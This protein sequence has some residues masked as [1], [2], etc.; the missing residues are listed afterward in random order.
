M[1][2]LF[3]NRFVK[4]FGAGFIWKILSGG[5]WIRKLQNTWGISLYIRT[6][7]IPPHTASLGLFLLWSSNPTNWPKSMHNDPNLAR[8]P[9]FWTKD[10]GFGLIDLDS[11]FWYPYFGFEHPHLDLTNPDLCTSDPDSGIES[12]ILDPRTQILA[13]ETHILALKAQIVATKTQMLD[14]WD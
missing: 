1:F 13:P 6:T 12:Q 10:H 5:K 7:S 9:I 8:K 3:I 14:S 11:R 2:L 4:N